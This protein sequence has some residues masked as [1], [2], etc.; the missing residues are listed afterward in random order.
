MTRHPFIS[1]HVKAKQD[2]PT[3]LDFPVGGSSMYLVLASS[4]SESCT[5]RTSCGRL[6]MI[7]SDNY[8]CQ[9]LLV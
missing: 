7:D 6:Q 5:M 9:G 8:D 3:K 4:L 2:L 1:S